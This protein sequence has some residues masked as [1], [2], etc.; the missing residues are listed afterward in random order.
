MEKANTPFSL[1][2]DEQKAQLIKEILIGHIYET[3]PP[4]LHVLA[5]MINANRRKTEEL[6]EQRYGKPIHRY[7]QDIKMKKI[8]RYVSENKLSLK[9]ISEKFGYNNQSALT[10]AFR[11][12]FGFTPSRLRQ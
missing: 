2:A 7:F 5:R 10:L 11:R 1:T 8:R 4:T 3:H 9:E 12:K 6:F